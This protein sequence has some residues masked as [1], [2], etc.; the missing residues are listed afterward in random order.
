MSQHVLQF[1]LSYGSTSPFFVGRVVT[2]FLSE[3]RMPIEKVPSDERLPGVGDDGTGTQSTSPVS[4]MRP[5]P[6]KITYQQDILYKPRNLDIGYSDLTKA[7]IFTI[8]FELDGRNF[9]ED[10][11][12][13]SNNSQLIFIEYDGVVSDPTPLTVSSKQGKKIIAI[14]VT[15]VTTSLIAASSYIFYL[16]RI[17]EHQRHTKSWDGDPASDLV[18]TDSPKLERESPMVGSFVGLKMND[19]V[20]VSESYDVEILEKS[21]PIDLVNHNQETV[22]DGV[23]N[24]PQNEAAATFTRSESQGYDHAA[25]ETNVE[26]AM[27]AA[28]ENSALQREH[29]ST[30]DSPFPLIPFTTSDVESGDLND[31]YVINY[32]TDEHSYHS[33][34]SLGSNH[35]DL[36]EDDIATNA[37]LSPA[38]LDDFA[39]PAAV[40]E[41]GEVRTEVNGIMEDAVEPPDQPHLDDPNIPFMMSGFQLEIRDLE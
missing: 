12:A 27:D 10:L 38:L 33:S 18:D 19:N 8:P 28:T 23:A 35:N 40:S 1:W 4:M 34:S 36:P 14:V 21:R 31:Y 37:P 25:V 16:M 30:E 17:K 2:T 29:L 24:V 39:V 7:N 15:V 13:I 22:P 3:Q 11:R 41:N 6:L 9:T 5:D 32:S 20:L 26:S